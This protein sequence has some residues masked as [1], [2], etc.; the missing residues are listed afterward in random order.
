MLQSTGA[1]RSWEKGLDS[2][3]RELYDLWI[4]IRGDGLACCAVED[5]KCEDFARGKC[6]RSERCTLQGERPISAVYP[7]CLHYWIGDRLP[8]WHVVFDGPVT[9][10]AKA[11]V[12]IEI[13]LIAYTCVTPEKSVDKTES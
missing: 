9:L 8:V 10:L 3:S 5:T 13:C 12:A 7:H 11:V 2:K 6:L 1:E 4:N